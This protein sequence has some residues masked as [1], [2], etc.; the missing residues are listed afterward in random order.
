MYVTNVHMYAYVYI[1]LIIKL[2]IYNREF[3]KWEKY[4]T[5]FGSRI[6]AKVHMYSQL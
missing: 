4:T 3:G 5:G 2:F 1:I 6:L